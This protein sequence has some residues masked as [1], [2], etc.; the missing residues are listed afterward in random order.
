MT[1]KEIAMYEIEKGIPPI[2][3]GQKFFFPFEQMDV[4][5][6]FLV[7]SDYERTQALMFAKRHGKKATSRTQPDG[8]YRIWRVE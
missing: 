7:K 1:T 4:G 8:T 2:H 6:S 5:D 3:T